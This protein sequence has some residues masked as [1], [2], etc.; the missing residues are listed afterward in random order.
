LTL[1]RSAPILPGVSLVKISAVVGAATVIVSFTMP[2]VRSELPRMK[3]WLNRDPKVTVVDVVRP[4]CEPIRSKLKV[5][6]PGARDIIALLICPARCC[7]PYPS[8]SR[9]QEAA[10]P[11]EERSA[12]HV[13]G[14]ASDCEERPDVGGVQSWGDGAEVL[15]DAVAAL[16]AAGAISS[17]T[18]AVTSKIF[19]ATRTMDTLP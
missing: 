16:Q 3:V 18:T 19:D 4:R 9:T 17:K 1:S 14:S 12:N 2:S 7:H 6:V 15:A 5:Y 13:Y 10:K 8:S 11:A